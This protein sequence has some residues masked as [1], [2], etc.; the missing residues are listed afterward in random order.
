LGKEWEGIEAG[1]I[2]VNHALDSL[3]F[4][5]VTRLMGDERRFERLIGGE[6]T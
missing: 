2:V 6:L 3:Q 4:A 1:A 5:A